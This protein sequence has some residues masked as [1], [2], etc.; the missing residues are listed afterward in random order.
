[1]QIIVFG[2]LF[3]A[4]ENIGLAEQILN[5]KGPRK[6]MEFFPLMMS[7]FSPEGGWPTGFKCSMD[8]FK[9]ILFPAILLAMGYRKTDS[10]HSEF[11]C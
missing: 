5:P 2:T 3:G 6:G 11:L 10:S 9:S 8:T 1:M 7:I 4:W